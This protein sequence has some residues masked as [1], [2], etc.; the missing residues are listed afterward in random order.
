MRK[1]I[2]IAAPVLLIVAAIS[3]WFAFQ[4]P[5]FVTALIASTSAMIFAAL[6]PAL[7]KIFRP[8]GE[9]A[10]KEWHKRNDRAEDWGLPGQRRRPKE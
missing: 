4:R 9:A 10:L 3:V 8:A 2:L 5:D 7:L 1:W 6:T